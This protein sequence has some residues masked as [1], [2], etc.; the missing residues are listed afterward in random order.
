MVEGYRMPKDHAI[1]FMTYGAQRD[2]EVFDDP[3][4]FKPERWLNRYT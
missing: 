3:D 2:P 1:L 4:V